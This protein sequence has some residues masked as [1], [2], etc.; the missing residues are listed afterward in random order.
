[1]A[2]QEL[3]ATEVSLVAGAGLFG[4]IGNGALNPVN[5]VVNAL[6][7]LDLGQVVGGLV[8]GVVGLLLNPLILFQAVDIG[9]IVAV[10]LGGNG[11]GGDL[12][13]LLGGVLS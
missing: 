1:M 12:N 8:A 13:A 10:L 7:N 2:I 5:G 3:N 11:L 4:N 6:V 9:G